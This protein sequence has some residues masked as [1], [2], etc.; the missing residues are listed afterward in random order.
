MNRELLRLY[1]LSLLV[2]PLAVLFTGRRLHSIFNLGLWVLAIPAATYGFV[3][4]LLVPIVDSL[5]VVREYDQETAAERALRV[6]I[7]R[8]RAPMLTERPALL[9][10]R[11]AFIEESAA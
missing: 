9:A 10:E 5:M 4:G 8:N 3:P 1:A 7:P 11:P 2:S 6:R